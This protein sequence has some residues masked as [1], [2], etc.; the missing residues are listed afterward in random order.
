MAHA[1]G[2]VR[3]S[4]VAQVD[5][6]EI[7]VEADDAVLR[8]LAQR[9]DLFGGLVRRDVRRDVALQQRDLQV[10]QHDIVRVD[11]SVSSVG[12]HG[13]ESILQDRPALVVDPAP[14]PL[15]MCRG[16]QLPAVCARLRPDA[17]ALADD[18][19]RHLVGQCH[20]AAAVHADITVI[21]SYI[22][23][24]LYPAIEPA[25]EPFALPVRQGRARRQKQH[26]KNQRQNLFHSPSSF[27]CSLH[28][29]RRISFVS[30]R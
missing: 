28:I 2:D 14:E 25:V 26:T 16:G 27:P 13:I 7:V 23:G 5:D 9:A 10:V 1:H 12:L 21:V 24:Q 29:R 30:C 22:R 11:P 6:V 19:H 18:R 15:A 3:S 17:C 8:Q 20:A 4:R